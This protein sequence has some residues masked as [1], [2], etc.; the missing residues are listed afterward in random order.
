MF[1]LGSERLC[2]CPAG[3]FEHGH[4]VGGRPRWSLR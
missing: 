1:E 4:R 2:H 3:G